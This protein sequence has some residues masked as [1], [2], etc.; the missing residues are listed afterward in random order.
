MAKMSVTWSSKRKQSANFILLEKW[1]NPGIK[2]KLDLENS[3]FIK[4]QS[5]IK[6]Y[7]PDQVKKGLILFGVLTKAV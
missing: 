5:S 7:L 1:N 2:K 4:D 3:L 6:A